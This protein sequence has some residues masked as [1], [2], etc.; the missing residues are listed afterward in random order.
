[1]ELKA[2][3]GFPIIISAKLS[4]SLGEI[5][6][7]Y[8]GK[9]IF[10]VFNIERSLNDPAQHRGLS[11]QQISQ[12]GMQIISQL[13]I[14]HKMGYTHG[15]LKFQNICY[16]EETKRYSLIDFALVTRIFHSNGQHKDQED[17]RS[18]FGNS[19]FAPDSMVS[20]KSTGRKDDIESFMYILCYL[21]KGMLP[22]VEFINENIDN[23]N[24]NQF[25]EKILA[26]RVENKHKCHQKV[27]EYLPQSLVPAFSYIMSLKFADR[28]DYNLIKLWMATDEEDEKN[29]FKTQHII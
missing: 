20:L 10:E 27:K 15:D 26:F 23:F 5:M 14:L 24:M 17:V 6:M 18:F 1:M 11:L 4:S 8:V 7:S 25:L 21:Y 28:P 16:N 22:V 12:L 9:D 29:V 2:N 13:E 3:G 19:L